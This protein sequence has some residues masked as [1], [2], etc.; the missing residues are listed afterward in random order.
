LGDPVPGDCGR[1]PADGRGSESGDPGAAGGHAMS[2]VYHIT[3]LEAGFDV[4]KRDDKIA[5]AR[6]WAKA[7]F[8]RQTVIVTRWRE[9][10]RCPCCGC[11]P[12]VG[13]ESAHI[14][15]AKARKEATS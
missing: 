15:H 7:A 14:E 2:P 10:G 9:G 1:R 11:T 5:D 8:P 12:C 4:L 6:R 13:C 3:I